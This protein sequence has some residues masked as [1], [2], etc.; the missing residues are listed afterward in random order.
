MNYGN[1]LGNFLS[2]INKSLNIVGKTLP[3]IKDSKPM[4]SNIKSLINSI[5]ST[6]VS[7]SI[8]KKTI[9]ENSNSPKFFI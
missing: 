9:T 7:K 6:P 2:G 3:I 8:S 4:I 1:L 5:N